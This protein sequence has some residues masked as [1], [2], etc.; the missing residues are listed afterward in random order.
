MATTSDLL[1]L[2]LS[3][4][5]CCH[6]YELTGDWRF[7]WDWASEGIRAIGHGAV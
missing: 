3:D 2:S 6:Q 7:H 1:N 5:L 4:S